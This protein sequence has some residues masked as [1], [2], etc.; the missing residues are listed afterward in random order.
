MGAAY[1]AMLQ[2]RIFPGT[3]DRQSLKPRLVRSAIQRKGCQLSRQRIPEGKRDPGVRIHAG[4][5]AYA[6]GDAFGLPWEGKMPGEIRLDRLDDVP[7]PEGWSQGS[8]TDD[9]ALTLLVA[10]HLAIARGKG[11]PLRFLEQLAARSG[12]IKGLGPSTKRAIA[13]FMATGEPDNSGSDTN[14][15]AMRALP[16]G[17]ALPLSSVGSRRDWTL[18]LTRMTHTGHN[19]LTA[20]CVMSACASWALEGAS[21]SELG[22]I[23][24]GEAIA[25]GP[26]TAVAEA[27]AMLRQDSWTPPS[28]GIS[29]SP[30]ETVTAALLCCQVTEGDLQT[31]FRMGVSLGGDTDT[32][33]ALIGGLLGCQLTPS[34]VQDQLTWLNKVKQP[35]SAELERLAKALADIRMTFDG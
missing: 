6:A 11:D 31:A 8:T 27:L 20:A 34:E 5:L 25:V 9:T 13:T 30:A 32:V 15:G 35:P 23:A 21:P 22:E 19:A 29:L 16:I 7:T 26:D 3:G 12:A 33:C 24:A 1:A 14:G 17:W 10:E 4:L 18:A 28:A 2:A